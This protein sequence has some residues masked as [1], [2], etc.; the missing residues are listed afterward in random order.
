MGYK[1]KYGGTSYRSNKRR[2]R[3][4]KM[5]RARRSTGYKNT[6]TGG[7]LGIEK[8]FY[9]TSRAAIAIPSTGDMS[10]LEVDPVTLNTI[11][12]PAEGNGES[13]RIGRQCTIHS[14][15]VKGIV[16]LDEV[17]AGGLSQSPVV[18]LALVQDK[19]SNGAQLD[20]EDVFVNP[21]AGGLLS[22]TPF[23]NLQYKQ[24]FKVLATQCI[25]MRRDIGF[26]DGANVDKEGVLIPFKMF[27]RLN[28]QANFSN[29]AAGIASCVD[30]SLH[31]IACC[32]TAS[33]CTLRYNAR[34]RFT[35]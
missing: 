16:E 15:T 2:T 8:K 25:T 26:A 24:R 33:A 29:T 32:T 10:S 22:V 35:G 20:S 31:V 28:I 30:N 7:Y 1:R 3:G 4:R 18:F 14:V 23:V 9:D 27:K 19:Q 11:S 5:Y 21:F 34:I 13:D 12:A 17:N 6:R